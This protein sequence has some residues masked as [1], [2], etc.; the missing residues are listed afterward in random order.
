MAEKDDKRTLTGDVKNFFT[1]KIKGNI[2]D[3]DISRYNI[4]DILP[5]P[6]QAVLKNLTWRWRASPQSN[7][8]TTL[9]DL[10]R[11]GNVRQI[12]RDRIRILRP[13]LLTE[14]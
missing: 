4:P 7:L 1:N 11:D 3:G 2:V 6:A 5:E 8:L 14:V 10:P 12:I 13:R 9:R